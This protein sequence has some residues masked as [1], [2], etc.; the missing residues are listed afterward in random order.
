MGG[1]RR[2]KRY[3]GLAQHKPLTTLWVH[4]CLHQ[5]SGPHPGPALLTPTP[6]PASL[7]S[8]G[9]TRELQQHPRTPPLPSSW[10]ALPS[11]T[12]RLA[13]LTSGLCSNNTIP[14]VFLDHLVSATSL[15]SPHSPY[16]SSSAL[17]S[18]RAHLT[19]VHLGV[20]VDSLSPTSLESHPLE[21]RNTIFVTAVSQ[22]LKVLTY[23]K[24]SVIVC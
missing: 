21:S 11:L 3:L 15:F 14:Q 7:F 1:L 20:F 5:A 4:P 2:E 19:S 13:P 12:H 9:T 8:T 22:G 24:Y 10:I 6:A 23:S 17:F 18:C 16:F